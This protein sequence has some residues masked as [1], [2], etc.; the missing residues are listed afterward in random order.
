MAEDGPCPLL[1]ELEVGC[2]EVENSY[3]DVLLTFTEGVLGAGISE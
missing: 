1:G 3:L 2:R